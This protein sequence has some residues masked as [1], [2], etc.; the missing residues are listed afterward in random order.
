MIARHLPEARCES[1]VSCEIVRT[2][3]QI[4]EDR[5]MLAAAVAAVLLIA[6]LLCERPGRM[7]F[8]IAALWGLLRIVGLTGAALCAGQL[9]LW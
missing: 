7:A 2:L 8:P 4:V 1:C 3:G 9:A 6:V 5:G